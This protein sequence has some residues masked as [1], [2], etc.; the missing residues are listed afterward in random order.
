MIEFGFYLMTQILAQS[1]TYAGLSAIQVSVGN[2][3]AAAVMGG[4]LWRAHPA[5]KS[6]LDHALSGTGV[7]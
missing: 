4:Y 7:D 2:L 6:G 1:P 5:L 3:V